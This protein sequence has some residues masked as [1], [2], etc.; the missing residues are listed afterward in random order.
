MAR[1]RKQIDPKK[2]EDLAMVGCPPNEIAAVLGCQ[3]STIERRFA[4]VV[5]KGADKGKRMVRSQLFK[6][7]MQGNLGA[8]CF[9]AKAWLGMRE[10]DPVNINVSANAVQTFGLSDD[11][12]KQIERLAQQIQFR[13]FKRQPEQP[14][15]AHNGAIGDPPTPALN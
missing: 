10:V 6:L 5:K 7:A 14:E 12:R 11:Q 1:P 9:L 8:A 4:A 3:T 2:V 15:P 13:A